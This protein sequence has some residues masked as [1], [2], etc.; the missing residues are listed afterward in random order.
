MTNYAELRER[1]DNGVHPILMT[2]FFGEDQHLDVGPMKEHIDFLFEKDEDGAIAGFLV[3]GANGEVYSMKPE[4][5]AQVVKA[6]V[7]Q[8][9]GRAPVV[10]G[11][12]EPATQETID[13]VREAKAAGA[14]CAMVTNPFYCSPTGAG[15]FA[16]Y[17]KI[18]ESV[19]GFPLM[20]YNNPVYTNFSM[21]LDMMVQLTNYPNFVAMKDVPASAQEFYSRCKRLKDKVAYIN[22]FGGELTFGYSSFVTG[23]T[24]TFSNAVNYAPEPVFALYR[25]VR[26]KD[27][28]GIKSAIEW[29]QPLAE[30][31]EKIC[32]YLDAWRVG[33]GSKFLSLVKEGLRWRGFDFGECRLPVLPLTN[34]E[35]AEVRKV[36]DSMGLKR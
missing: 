26:D 25:A 29:L 7:N 9:R 15:V 28:K 23:C 21:P 19:D 12:V 4:E 11:A 31:Y 8:I 32:P 34:E 2:P 20:I 10:A 1:L 14:D 24:S 27:F 16:H 33:G 18:F 3:A 5:R 13:R 17:R 36:L 22:N 35:K 6:A 30:L